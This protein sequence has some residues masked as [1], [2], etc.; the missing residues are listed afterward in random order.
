[1]EMFY[2]QNFDFKPLKRQ[3][4]GLIADRV[5]K[6]ITTVKREIEKGIRTSRSPVTGQPFAPITETTKE[7][8]A[9]RRQ[10][11][12]SKNKPL[13]ATGKMS[14]L[15]RKN[16]KARGSS[17]KGT[18]TMGREYGAYH[19]IGYTIKNN[20]TVSGRTRNI[21]SASGTTSKI[22]G[23]G[24]FFRVKGKKVPMRLWF[25]VPSNYKPE[26]GFRRLLNKMQV[27]LK[28]GKPIRRTRIG[29]LVI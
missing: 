8:R 22:K 1:M 21:K 3:I 15:I 17:F 27:A 20:F 13:L 5:N 26:V 12:K 11:R 19:N 4:P 18:L 2:S 14:K 25:G 7:V 10:N 9:L 24:R 23:K 28:S 16:A 6:D 29:R